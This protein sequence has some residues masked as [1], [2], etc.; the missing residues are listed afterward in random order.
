MLTFY[1]L[2]FFATAGRKIEYTTEIMTDSC[3]LHNT[4]KFMYL[5]RDFYQI[6]LYKTKL[7][8]D[9]KDQRDPEN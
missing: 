3:A 2:K 5:L 8:P 7:I 9:G 4:V 6:I 1:E